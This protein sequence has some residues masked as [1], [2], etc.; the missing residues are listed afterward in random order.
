MSEEA[1]PRKG[2]KGPDR[3]QRPGL[4]AARVS[5][6]EAS[7][8]RLMAE[9]RGQSI[10]SLLR[11]SLLQIPP[12]RRQRRPRA[13]EQA[14]ARLLGELAAVKA[15]LGKSGSNLNQIAHYLN[16]D[17]GVGSLLGM[18]ESAL[19]DHDEAMRTLLELRAACLKTLGFREAD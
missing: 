7:A 3:R 13:D 19:A 16:A 11:E 6:V 2:R 1:L 14:I 15:E 5:P 18:L 9:T 12:P 8:I 10:G 17:R 4:I